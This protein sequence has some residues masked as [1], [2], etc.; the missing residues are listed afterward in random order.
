MAAEPSLAFSF[1]AG[2]LSFLSPCMLP[3]IPA[4]IAHMAGTNLEDNFNRKKVFVTALLFVTGFSVV[5]GVMGVLL[6]SFLESASTQILHYLSI[7]AG[8]LIIFF[9]AHLTGI[10]SIP[11]FDTE[12]KLGLEDK[13]GS[14]Y[15]SSIILGAAFAVGWTPCVGPILGSVFALASASPGSAFFLLVAY[16][17]G[18]G[19]PFL[20]I[21]AFPNKFREYIMQRMD[22]VKKVRIIFGYVMILM[23]VLIATQNLSLLANFSILNEVL[24]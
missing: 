11:S 7:F 2:L 10:I 6:N 16:S 13:L 17:V 3:V 23:G 8:S 4:F 22:A 21:G 14:G 5:F 15:I 18:L 24:L 9:G 19:T 1:L 20:L 12:H